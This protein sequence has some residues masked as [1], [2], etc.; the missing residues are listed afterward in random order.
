MLGTQLQITREATESEEGLNCE[1]H[2]NVLAAFFDTT[3]DDVC[4][5]LF[6]HWGRGK[7]YLINRVSRILRTKHRYDVI[8]FSAWKYRST[9]EVWAHLYETVASASRAGDFML[10]ILAP[11][12]AMLARYGLWPIIVA[13]VSFGFSLY[14]VNDKLW[15]GQMALQFLGFTGITYFLLLFI[16]LQGFARSHVGTS[17]KQPSHREKLGLQVAIGDDLRALL[18]GWMPKNFWLPIWGGFAENPGLKGVIVFFKKL[19]S[20]FILSIPNLCFI[21]VYAFATFFVFRQLVSDDSKTIRVP[22]YGSVDAVLSKEVVNLVYAAWGV[23]SI[24][25]PL[26][27]FFLAQGPKRLLLVVDD[28]DRCEPVQMLE[29]IESVMLLLDDKDIQRRLQIVM[30]VEEEAL[31]AA[32]L[33]KYGHLR[34]MAAEGQKLDPSIDDR[35]VRENV[36]KFFV[37]Y[38]RLPEIP[39]SDF[40][41][42]VKKYIEANDGQ[43]EDIDDIDVDTP[44]DS[45]ATPTVVPTEPAGNPIDPSNPISDGKKSVTIGDEK[46]K[47]IAPLTETPKATGETSKQAIEYAEDL[48]LS[49][50]ERRLL[51]KRFV[52][53]RESGRTDIRWGPRTVRC[54]LHKYRLARALWIALNPK[55]GFDPEALLNALMPVTPTQADNSDHLLAYIVAQVS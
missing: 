1:E 35:I 54:Y 41:D 45:D 11:F 43:P 33:M 32:L 15:F 12:R 50:R 28:L 53:L 23:F 48:K 22:F 40:R 3:T 36:E 20:R 2:A 25:L 7:T 55:T 4:F 27:A 37:S 38:L 14:T 13:Y 47:E 10:N 51:L 17:L 21:S 19:R 8:R 42:L 52:A 26:S 39:P 30:L 6:G 44:S 24:V 46:T 18:I 16:R 5:G 34:S 9:P 49:G 29:I 31:R